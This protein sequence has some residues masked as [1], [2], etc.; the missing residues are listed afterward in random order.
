MRGKSLLKRGISIATVM[1]M[2]MTTAVGCGKTAKENE[3]TTTGSSTT[4]SEYTYVSEYVDVQLSDSESYNT[5]YLLKG[6]YL[7][8]VNT[9]YTDEESSSEI[10]KQSLTDGSKTELN[11]DVTSNGYVDYF[12]V[13]DDGSYVTFIRESED[14]GSDNYSETVFLVSYDSNGTEIN[15]ADITEVLSDDYASAMHLSNQGKVYLRTESG[16]TVFDQSFNQQ[17]KI[18]YDGNVAWVTESC[19]G[20]DD[21]MYVLY[22]G[23]EAAGYATKLARVDEKGKKLVD[24]SAELTMLGG[25]KMLALEDNNFLLSDS[26]SLLKVNSEGGEANNIFTWLSC[27]I[28]GMDVSE[29]SVAGEDSYYA[30]IEDTESES[31]EIMKISKVKSS[32]V[33]P[34]KEIILGTFY[35]QSSVTSAVL[36]YNKTHSDYHITVKSYYDIANNDEDAYTAALTAMNND[37][38]SDNCPDI[39]DLS[40][41]NIA[42]LVQK[43][44]LED[45]NAY[46]GDSE[47]KKEDLLDSV[48]NGYTY[49]NKLIAIP[50]TVYFETLAGS[51]ADVGNA[52]GW[53]VSEMMDVINANPDKAFMEYG[54]KDYM[55]SMLVTYNQEK[56]ID[57][58]NGTCNF[59]SQD[60]IDTLKFANT[61]PAEYNYSEEELMESTP[62]KIKNGKILMA[63][64]TIDSPESIQK[65]QAFFPGEC[66][67]IGFPSNDG[68]GTFMQSMGLYGIASKSAVKDGA[69]EFIESALL[70]DK[71]DIYS[72]GFS[73]VKSL[74]E[75][76]ITESQ[77]VEYV[78]DENGEYLLDENGEKIIEGGG[79]VDYGDWEYTYHP[80]TDE[81]ADIFRKLIN[82]AKASQTGDEKISQIIAEEASAYFEGQKAP[83]DVAE[84]IQSRVNIYIKEIS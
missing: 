60:F 82:N 68:N 38:L 35:G 45:L 66:N 57:W 17:E 22:T 6:D 12:D 43:G 67:F 41:V 75:K 46:M 42:S 4:S 29:V 36:N 70:S 21:S 47:L 5:N 48:V 73:P 20:T 39:L 55:I 84:I 10:I 78:K 65:I 76:M 81:E 2:L 23:S 14:D 63:S 83:E 74:V 53:T 33:Q 7:Y 52:D 49:D 51:V 77:N 58:T 13:A 24:T 28:N 25:N 79:S 54:T 62:A 19:I 40:S 16:I 1:A 72:F 9:R 15:R 18:T 27:D 56:Y 3:S 31:A 30:L 37:I 50:S 8:Y 59:T 34:K 61:F 69:W 11:V 80:V 26:D 64:A 71:K 44:L 32:E